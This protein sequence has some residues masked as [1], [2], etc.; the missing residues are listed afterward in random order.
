MVTVSIA[1]VVEE[2]AAEAAVVAP[3]E[4][5]GLETAEVV[6]GVLEEVVTIVV[7]IAEAATEEEEVTTDAVV[8]DIIAAGAAEEVVWKETLA[9]V[10]VVEDVAETA[11]LSL[12]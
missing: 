2:V 12:A 11:A 7:D 1:G 3:G 9:E 10:E 6:L 8:L 5:G 4:A